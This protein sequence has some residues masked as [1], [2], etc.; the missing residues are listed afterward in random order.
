[1]QKVLERLEPAPPPPAMFYTHIVVDAVVLL[2]VAFDALTRALRVRSVYVSHIG[3]CF[4][5]ENRK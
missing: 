4:D 1:M 5:T 3:V 2:G